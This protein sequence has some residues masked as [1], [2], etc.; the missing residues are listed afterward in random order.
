VLKSTFAKPLNYFLSIQIDSGETLRTE[1]AEE[2]KHPVFD[3]NRFELS[4]GNDDSVALLRIAAIAM[5]QEN[6]SMMLGSCSWDLN[7]L[8]E[9]PESSMI[10]D[11]VLTRKS[12]KVEGED[13]VVG[14]VQVKLENITDTGSPR[15]AI[16][17]PAGTRLCKTC[18][19]SCT[20][21][22]QGLDISIQGRFISEE[23]HFAVLAMRKNEIS[24][25]IF[26][27][28]WPPSSF[29]T[30]SVSVLNGGSASFYETFYSRV[31]TRDLENNKA[32]RLDVMD[33]NSQSS[34]GG[35]TVPIGRLKAFNQ[36]VLRVNP[37]QELSFDISL[38]LQPSIE[39][40]ISFYSKLPSANRLKLL[41]EGFNDSLPD[42]VKNPYAE[43]M[44]SMTGDCVLQS[45][46]HD[47]PPLEDPL[48][49][50]AALNEATFPFEDVELCSPHFKMGDCPLETSKNWEENSLDFWITDSIRYASFTFYDGQHRLFGQASVQI[51]SNTTSEISIPVVLVELEETKAAED[52]TFTVQLHRW[53]G[54]EYVTYLRNDIPPLKLNAIASPPTP[55]LTP[56]PYSSSRI[57]TPTIIQDKNEEIIV[58]PSRAR[59]RM[60]HDTTKNNVEQLEERLGILGADISNKQVLIDRLLEELDQRSVAIR[61]CGAEIVKVRAANEQLAKE[62]D[63][64]IDKIQQMEQETYN[65][66]SEPVEDSSSDELKRRIQ[67]LSTKYSNERT[68]NAEIMERLAVL[69]ASMD[70]KRNLLQELGS[71][72]DAHVSQAK[73]IQELQESN[74]EVELYKKTIQTQEKVIMKLE[75]I[76][77]AKLQEGSKFDTKKYEAEI[78]RLAQQNDQ[79]A[80]QVADSTTSEYVQ[81]LEDELEALREEAN[82]R[83]E[84]DDSDLQ[85]RLESMQQSLVTNAK[86]FAKEKSSFITK[87]FEYEAMIQAS[88]SD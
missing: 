82:N 17:L 22:G 48:A 11:L 49:K 13:I 25:E 45:I 71:L 59:S 28:S 24:N 56:I 9:N 41:L 61:S 15:K 65:K 47:C 1:V 46:Y 67:L 74:E 35:I 16:S 88:D 23:T 39:D 76:L 79:L 29:E 10:A 34:I 54:N 66:L 55:Q 4:I 62:R 58:S 63:N 78:A 68:R 72:R 69:Q 40:D 57:E 30:K 18:I 52:C 7:K 51:D 44:F 64:A 53:K 83:P 27:E 38:E 19:R 32:L 73:Y 20:L 42:Y 50:G 80:N 14:K 5:I 60:E 70:E 75:D 8:L 6:K 21:V 33:L 87:I 26:E 3:N 43:V 86:A 36:Y 31:D 85:E 77:E 37:T 84:S 12:K 2:S 81:K